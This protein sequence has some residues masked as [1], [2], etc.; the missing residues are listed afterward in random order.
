MPPDELAPLIIGFG[1]MVVVPI[2]AM[3]LNH[4]RKMA[5][6]IHKRQGHDA[7]VETRIDQMQRQIEDLRTLLYDHTIRMDDQR[8]LMRKATPP[9]PPEADEIARRLG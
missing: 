4:Q 1:L 3:M 6:L 5:E 2:V 9:A 7:G 8:E